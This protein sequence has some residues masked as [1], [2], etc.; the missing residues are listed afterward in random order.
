MKDVLIGISGN[1]NYL[2]EKNFLGYERTYI[3]QDYV[4][5]IIGVEAL[6]IILP[7]TENLDVIKEYAK[8][9]DGL[10][11]SGGYDVNPKMYNEDPHRLLGEILPKR[12]FFEA[13][14]IMEVFKLRK[15][16]FGICRGLQLI[17][18][19]FGGTLYQDLSLADFVKVK[20]EQDAR[21][22]I[23]THSVKL[24][25]IL[26]ELLESK[27]YNV[28]SFHHQIIKKLAN[29]FEVVAKANDDVIE[30]I[31]YDKDEHFILALQWHPEMMFSND[32]NARKI[33]RKFAQKVYEVKNKL[34]K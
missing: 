26:E 32:E 28:N 6:P 20:H 7:I 13:N 11:I 15:P 25:G 31:F 1:M 29:D 17:N 8:R 27:E 2:N 4:N 24:S 16:I 5:S 12:D 22:D 9:I 3:S 18:V 23:P 10:V 21:W 14:L 33:F 19:V 34:K 30:A